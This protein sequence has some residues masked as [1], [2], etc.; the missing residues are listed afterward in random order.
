MKRI[1]ING[2]NG[3]VASN[4]IN[5]LKK[6]LPLEIIPAPNLKHEEMNPLERLMAVAMSFTGTNTDVKFDTSARDKAI[7]TNNDEMNES[8]LVNILTYFLENEYEKRDLFR[9]KTCFQIK[10][11][12]H[13]N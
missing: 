11:N 4:F 7:T 3:Y 1:I 10:T 9:W 8:V 12:L 5:A 6:L 2:A 13:L